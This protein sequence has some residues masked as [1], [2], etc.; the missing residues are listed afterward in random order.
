M[1]PHPLAAF[2][3]RRGWTEDQVESYADE[4]RRLYAEG[5]GSPRIAARVG[6]GH[7]IVLKHLRALGVPIHHRGRRRLPRPPCLRCGAEAASPRHRYCAACTRRL[8]KRYPRP[9]PRVCELDG[10]DVVFTPQAVKVAAGA[11]RFC[12]YDHW[13]EW[14]RGRPQAGWR[15]R[16]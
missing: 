15:R 10:C 4:L 7:R 14:R 8:R 13:N 2:A 6:C 16:R 11:G 5:Y 3:A 9:E 12:S 1:H